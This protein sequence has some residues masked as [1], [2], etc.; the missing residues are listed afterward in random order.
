MGLVTISGPDNSPVLLPKMINGECVNLGYFNDGKKD[1]VRMEKRE[2]KET[3]SNIKNKFKY[4]IL[5]LNG[6]KGV[7]SIF[8]NEFKLLKEDAFN[9][10]VSLEEY[11]LFKVSVKLDKVITLL[12]GSS[13]Y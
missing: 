8:A 3:G 9:C 13:D 2:R 12:G 6:E 10:N 5:E 4:D 11:L 7:K 1:N